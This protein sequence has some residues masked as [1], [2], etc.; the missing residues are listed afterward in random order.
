[1]DFRKENGS[2]P[3]TSILP[4]GVVTCPVFT[5][6]IKTSFLSALVIT[7]LIG[8]ACRSQGRHCSPQKCSHEMHK[9]TKDVA[10]YGHK[11]EM[12]VATESHLLYLDFSSLADA[13]SQWVLLG[14]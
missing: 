13:H 6:S 12:D 9:L 3:E 8:M 5:K 1:M 2:H 4:I 7:R 10:I 11:K 14:N